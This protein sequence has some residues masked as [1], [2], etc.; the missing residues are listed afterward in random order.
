MGKII[1]CFSLFIF[2]AAGINAQENKIN[3]EKKDA[4]AILIRATNADDVFDMMKGRITGSFVQNMPSV[5]KAFWYKIQQEIDNTD[6]TEMLIP[7]YDEKFTLEEIKKLN[8]FY[9]SEV[10]RKMT[11][12][13][14]EINKEIFEIAKE[15]SIKKTD[16]IYEKLEEEGHIKPETE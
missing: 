9:T 11:E 2:F 4:I 14:K 8:E 5:P 3:K 7:V 10:G 1:A 15:W 16:E 13:R 6:F 12:L